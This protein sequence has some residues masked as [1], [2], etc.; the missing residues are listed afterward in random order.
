M[1]LYQLLL[2][3]IF[4]AGIITW[5]FVQL[6]KFTIEC[7]KARSFKWETLVSPGG[8]PSSHTASMVAISAMIYFLEGI[9][10]TFVLAI[11]ITAVI[12][13]DSLTLRKQVGIITKKLNLESRKKIRDF[14]GHTG[15]QVLIGFIIG[16]AIAYLI[17]WI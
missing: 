16:I 1:A 5:V 2:N 11:A 13:Y 17:K 8:M 15:L 12:M 3:K 7:V 9:S 14:S 10:S 4:L 6:L